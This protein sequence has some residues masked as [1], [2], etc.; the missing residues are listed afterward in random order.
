MANGTFLKVKRRSFGQARREAR[1]D[2]TLRRENGSRGE[3][4]LECFCRATYVY[5]SLASYR[6]T[7]PI[8]PSPLEAL[9][10]RG[11]VGGIYLKRDIPARCCALVVF[12]PWAGRAILVD[13]SLA[14]VG[15]DRAPGGKA[16]TFC[17]SA[18]YAAPEMIARE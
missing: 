3:R 9:C 6:D 18:A 1:G 8:P 16:M 11:L 10:S 4:L 2:H 7:Y 5:S 15:L 13:F 12:F 17:G 14:R